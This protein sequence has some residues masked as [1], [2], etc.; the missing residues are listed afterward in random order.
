MF[1]NFKHLEKKETFSNRSL[2]FRLSIHQFRNDS[3]YH[4]SKKLNEQYIKLYY[5]TSKNI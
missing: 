2:R 1:Q 5:D 4:V 3:N